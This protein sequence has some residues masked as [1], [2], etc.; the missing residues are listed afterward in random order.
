MSGNEEKSPGDVGSLPAEVGLVIEYSN[1][2]RVYQLD[3]FLRDMRWPEVRT[4]SASFKALPQHARLYE[5]SRA[6]L[7][8]AIVLCEQAAEAGANL[9]WPRASVCYYCLHLATELFLKACILRV[10]GKPAKSHE[11][12]DLLKRYA[13]LFPGQEN[14]F[15]TPWSLSACDLDDAVGCKVLKGVDR[16]PDQLYRYGMDKD[17][18][19]SSGTQFFT[20][21]YFFNYARHL[22]VKWH[23]VW[24]N[25]AGSVDG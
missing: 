2:V 19:G 14:Q 7:D 9:E 25:A 13:E 18:T 3:P 5:Q 8:A 22:A 6:F 4:D 21:G 24:S 16:V 10:G 23:E 20:P 12:A 11:I 15:P 1:G 17:G